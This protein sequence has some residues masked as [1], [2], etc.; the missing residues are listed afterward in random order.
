MER[1]TV[2]APSISLYIEIRSLPTCL[3][4]G[5]GIIQPKVSINKKQQLITIHHF[6]Q[7]RRG[8]INQ[9]L[10]ILLPIMKQIKSNE[11]GSQTILIT[12][13]T[14]E[15]QLQQILFPLDHQNISPLR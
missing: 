10:E 3:S 6:Q 14:Q 7:S 12:N 8:L 2:T 11:D 4:Y 9:G 13:N 1:V 5:T 15:K